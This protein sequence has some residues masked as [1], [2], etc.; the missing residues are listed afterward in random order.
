MSEDAGERW[1]QLIQS[2]SDLTMIA[3]SLR[4]RANRLRTEVKGRKWSGPRFARARQ[5]LRDEADQCILIAHRAEEM[6]SPP[7]PVTGQL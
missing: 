3:R 2:D 4:A 1:Y 6:A 5:M 7:G